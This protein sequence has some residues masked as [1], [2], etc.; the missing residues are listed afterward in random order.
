[1]RTRAGPFGPCPCIH[2]SGPLRG[3]LL[4]TYAAIGRRPMAAYT[5]P[6]GRSPAG[7]VRGPVPRRGTGPIRGGAKP[8][9]LYE[10]TAS[11]RRPLAVCIH[12]WAAK[13]PSCV[14][15]TPLG[16][17]QRS[18]HSSRWAKPTGCIRKMNKYFTRKGVAES[19]QQQINQHAVKSTTTN[20]L[21]NGW[22]VVCV[23]N[24]S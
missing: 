11:G 14:R 19:K 22:W 17:A 8:R 13:Q 20:H 18:A 10:H 16:E 12:S 24:L 7:H 15:C 1:M 21:I 23:A 4:C 2:R 5:C 3:P 9:P 6:A